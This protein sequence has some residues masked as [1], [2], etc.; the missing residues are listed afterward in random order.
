[1]TLCFRKVSLRTRQRQ[2]F[3]CRRNYE[4]KN[5]WRAYLK[6]HTSTKSWCTVWQRNLSG[7]WTIHYLGWLE[8]TLRSHESTLYLCFPTHVFISPKLRHICGTSVFSQFLLVSSSYSQ[9][10]SVISPLHIIEWRRCSMQC[11]GWILACKYDSVGVQKFLGR[12]QNTYL[13]GR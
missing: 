1:M 3:F 10:S 7:L 2:V 9:R 8:F 13:D 4:K 11:S 5:G 12:S 6:T